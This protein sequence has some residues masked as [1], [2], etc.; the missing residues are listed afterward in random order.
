MR[1]GCVRCSQ[2]RPLEQKKTLSSSIPRRCCTRRA[3]RRTCAM[4]PV[5][6]A[7]HCGLARLAGFWTDS[8][9]LAVTEPGGVLCRIAKAKRVEL[10][11]RFAGVSIE[12]LRD[13]AT[14]TD[15]SLAAVIGKS[16]AR[17]ML[18]VKKASPSAGAI[19]TNADPAAL[20]R[21]YA[22][23]ADALS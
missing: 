19:R 1:R 9:R 4:A 15:R 17:F 14:S 12:K 16:G 6:R 3:R 10:D 2:A 18:E 22:G 20:A 23:V 5:M 7:R 11:A 13:F 21:G 8:W